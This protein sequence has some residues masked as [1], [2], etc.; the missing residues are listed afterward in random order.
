MPIFITASSRV[1][2]WT[3]KLFKTG[4]GVII[5][6]QP[7]NRSSYCEFLNAIQKRRA[8]FPPSSLFLPLYTIETFL[9]QPYNKYCSVKNELWCII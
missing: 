3:I 7:F 8:E 4:I 2:T 1:R 9:N 5:F 6:H